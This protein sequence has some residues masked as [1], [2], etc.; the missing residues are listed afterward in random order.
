[1]NTDANTTAPEEYLTGSV[2]ENDNLAIF[3]NYSK[4]AKEQE[5]IKFVP[6]NDTEIVISADE[7]L[8]IVA[9]QLKKKEL[10][11]ALTTADITEIPMIET[12]RP[13]DVTLEKDFKKGDKIQ[14]LFPHMYPYF[15]AVAEEAYKL[16]ETR[17]DIKIITKDAY[18]EVASTLIEKNKPFIEAMYAEALSKNK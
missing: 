7:I 13:L 9:T 15:L 4:E 11:V 1:M 5:L 12:M 3:V 17:G 10:A 2:A 14:F 8:S 16:C 18:D 6:K